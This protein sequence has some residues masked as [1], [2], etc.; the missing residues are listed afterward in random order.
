MRAFSSSARL[1]RTKNKKAEKR[2]NNAEKA[3]LA[4]IGLYPHEKLNR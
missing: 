1:D 4:A 2:Q 3:G